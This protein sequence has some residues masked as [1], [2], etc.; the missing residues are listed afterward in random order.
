MHAHTHT[1]THA[2]TLTHLVKPALHALHG[3]DDGG[4]PTLLQEYLAKLAIIGAYQLLATAALYNHHNRRDANRPTA[5]PAGAG[6]AAA[7][8][9]GS[10]A[11][12]LEDPTA[13]A[14]QGEGGTGGEGPGAGNV[15]PGRLLQRL[16]GPLQ[17]LYLWGFLPLE[18]Y[19][20]WLHGLTLGRAGRLPFVPLMLTSVYCAVGVVWVWLDMVLEY[21]GAGGSVVVG[22]P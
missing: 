2:G 12:A 18:L 4:A 14:G 22:A 10:A 21:A 19:C 11:A 7:A 17:R 15:G 16:L 13:P 3:H 1:R 5:G 6:S 8:A 9:A 20:S